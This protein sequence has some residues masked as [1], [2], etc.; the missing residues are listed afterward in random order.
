MFR[1]SKGS[2]WTLS[3]KTESIDIAVKGRFQ[4]NS[5]GMIR[6]LVSLG[7]GIAAMPSEIVAE[8]L[9]NGHIQRIITKWEAPSTPVY[10]MTETRLLPAKTQR[11]IEFLQKNLR[12]KA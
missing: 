12:T 6:K 10:A 7:M 5:V 11:F 9:M 3:N 1:S 2:V 8:D 4:V